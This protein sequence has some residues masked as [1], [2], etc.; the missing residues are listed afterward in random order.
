M[1]ARHGVVGTADTLRL[2]KSVGK[3]DVKWGG[4]CPAGKEEF[5]TPNYLYTVE[6]RRVESP[7]SYDCV[8][9]SWCTSL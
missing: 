6:G 9:L 3:S 1:A 5:K 4:L 7:S 8:T 2:L